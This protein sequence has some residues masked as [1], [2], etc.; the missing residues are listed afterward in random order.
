MTSQ[1]IRKLALRIVAGMSASD[2]RS[3]KLT[4][5]DVVDILEE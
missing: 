1:V 4:L 5:G 3:L 2:L